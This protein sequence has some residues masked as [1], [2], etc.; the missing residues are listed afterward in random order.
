MILF[1]IV[2]LFLAFFRS[3]PI[4]GKDFYSDYVCPDQ[5]RSINGI[6]IL[7]ILLSHTFAKLSSNDMLDAV[8][9]SVRVFLGQFVVVPFLFYSG[10]GIMDSISK[11]ESYLR[12]FPKKRF[13][14]LATQFFLISLLYIP[15]HLLLQSDYSVTDYLLSFLGIRSVGNGG[16]FMLSTFVYYI[17]IIL[18]FHL[19]KRS[20]VAA[21]IATTGCLI[22]LMVIEIML[23]FPSY[24]YSTTIFF[25][26][27]MFYC[28]LKKYF[29]QLVMKNNYTW[30]IFFL[31]GIFGFIFL[32][33]FISRSVLF[34][35]IWCG[36]GML[37]IL[38][39]TMKVKIQNNVLIWLGKV[40]FFIF[41]LQGIPQ[42]IFSRLLQ[43]NYLYYIT[44]IACSLI[45][46][47]FADR[48]FNKPKTLTAKP[49]R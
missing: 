14:R 19:F 37:T 17:S 40:V 4:W 23:D 42:N 22:A 3:K 13:L 15:M 28:L 32:K 35:P 31:A 8:Y 9:T 20:K 39:L 12:T 46:A 7:L 18:C 2:V 5:T 44:V 38:C 16:W 36:F 45:L 11:K 34:Y 33:G 25:A 30:A 48:I 41:T 21:V 10:Y 24:Y 6:F 27:G 1:F 29:D 49:I 43:N 26:V 47:F